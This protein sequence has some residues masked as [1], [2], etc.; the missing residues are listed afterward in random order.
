ME[1]LTC[2]SDIFLEA[3]EEVDL[4]LEAAGID[5]IIYSDFFKYFSNESVRL[6][7]FIERE[8]IKMLKNLVFCWLKNYSLL[9]VK[10]TNEYDS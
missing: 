4:D 8:K 3:A 9:Y 7:P 2:C 6:A 5:D 10:E 1:V